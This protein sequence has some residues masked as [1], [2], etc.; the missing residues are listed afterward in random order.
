MKMKYSSLLVSGL[1]LATFATTTVSADDTGVAN[2]GQLIITKDFGLTDGVLSPKVTFTFDVKG[3]DTASGEKDGLHVYSGTNYTNGLDTATVTY[4]NNSNTGTKQQTTTV[5]FSKV[6]YD[7]PGIY[8]YTVTEQT[9]NIP[10]VTYDTKTYTVDVYVLQENGTYAPKYVVSSEKDTQDKKPIQFNNQ[11]KTTRLK[12]SKEVTGNAGDKNKEFTFSI[13]LEDKNTNKYY[14]NGK[15]SMTITK[16]DDQTEN[17]EVS[18]GAEQTFTLKDG[19]SATIDKLPQGIEYTVNE[20]GDDGYKQ[21][22]TINK[23]TTA[24]TTEAYTLGTGVTSDETADEIVV[25]NTKD[26]T[27]P[28]GVAMTVAPYVGLTILALGGVLYVLKKRKA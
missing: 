8:R 5:D 24:S 14:E 16:K 15:V 2:G 1:A 25:T 4:D 20:T 19:E 27:T 7:K 18:L 3:G 26:S 11:I 6:T 12:V 17:V 21:S 22:A 9:G 28:T 23:N 10:G 13:K